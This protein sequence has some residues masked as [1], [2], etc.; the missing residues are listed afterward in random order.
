MFQLDIDDRAAVARA[1]GMKPSEVV[2]AAGLEGGDGELAS[3][4][5]QTHDGQRVLVAPGGG[6]T[7]WDGP[8]PGDEVEAPVFES[9]V[10]P[11][12]EGDG[13]GPAGEGEVPG[14]TADE[15]LAWVGED[16]ERATR[17]LQAEQGRDKPRTTLT[18][19]L[20]KLAGLA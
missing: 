14:G 1:L 2:A 5:V 9:D 11:P 10:E 8:M 7:P 15:V 18:T 6:V 4:V 3:V 20:E 13:T 16:R 17:A 19:Q 12:D